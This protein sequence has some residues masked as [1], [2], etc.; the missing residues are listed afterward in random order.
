MQW[1]GLH[2]ALGQYLTLAG[3]EK[4][5]LKMRFDG[6]V[7][8]NQAKEGEGEAEGRA[9]GARSVCKGAALLKCRTLSINCKLLRLVQAQRAK[10][11]GRK[12]EEVGKLKGHDIQ[13]ITHR[14]RSGWKFTGNAV[15]LK[16]VC[17]VE[18][19]GKGKL[20][21]C[22][23]FW[24]GSHC[25]GDLNCSM[26]IDHAF[27]WTAITCLCLSLT[28]PAEL[29]KGNKQYKNIGHSGFH[30]YWFKVWEYI[31]LTEQTILWVRLASRKTFAKKFLQFLWDKLF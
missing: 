18:R 26:S 19:T 24:S 9:E 28:R 8:V 2:S 1:W 4:L 10:A 15:S 16:W 23:L 27:D 3:F 20:G 6:W 31:F 5:I 29:A 11:S 12:P 21:R 30:T 13:S 7:E 25:N 22:Q 14:F 17:T